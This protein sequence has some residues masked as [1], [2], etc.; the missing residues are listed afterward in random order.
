MNLN[1]LIQKFRALFPGDKTLLLSSA[2]GR[3]NLIGEHTDYNNGF[4]MPLAIEHRIQIVFC[5]N[6]SNMVNLYSCN[7]DE[8]DSFILPVKEKSEKQWSNYI[9]GI[10]KMV[11]DDG[12][13]VA[14]MDAVLHG[15]I[16]IGSGLSSSAAIE[17][18]ALMAVDYHN[19]LNIDPLSQ[20]E[21]AQKCE[22]QFVGVDCGIMDQFVSRMGRT[23]CALLIDCRNLTCRHIEIDPSLV[24]VIANTG[25]KHNLIDSEYNTRRQECQAANRL[26]KVASLRDLS[27]ETF[28]K[29][30][31][32]LSDTI[33]KR[34]TH[35]VNENQRV[36]D[37]AQAFDDS[38]FIK[39]GQLMYESH[40]SLK[41]D[42]AVSCPELDIMVEIAT[43]IRGVYGCRMT[44]AGFGGCTVSLVDNDGV[45]AFCEIM[46]AS[47]KEKTGDCPDIYITTPSAGGTVIEL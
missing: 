11:Q 30:K 16:P 39:A 35:V 5:P 1:G 21:L 20:V 46:K 9:R 14:G 41:D 38:D 17:V 28:D 10:Y 4:V 27:P 3:V 43:S 24:I 44:G 26:L 18:A 12:Y 22:N 45:I 34:A 13:D 6:A 32:L 29:K 36:L 25:I 8:Y 42:Y 19:E 31:H 47:Y 37:V 40:Y 7:Y 15:N 23:G 33:R 2:P